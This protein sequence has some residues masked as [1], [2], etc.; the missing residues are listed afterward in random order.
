MLKER[1]KKMYYI[2]ITLFVVYLL[3]L[4][5]VILFKLEFSLNELER[6]RAYN[7]IPFHYEDG[8]NVRFHFSEVTNNVLIFI[9]VGIYLSLFFKKVPL[10]G[11]ASLI[12]AVSLVLECSQYILAVGR[13]DI[14]DIITNTIGGLLGMGIYIIS[15]ALF[16]NKEKAEQAMAI[17]VNII[18]VSL[19]G[20]VFLLSSMN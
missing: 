14:T 4:V 18:T 8:H 12:F 2:T 1:N 13:F 10:W 6:I 15:C 11:K 17:L 5:W 9:P 20:V 19:V 7:F 3:F 16:R